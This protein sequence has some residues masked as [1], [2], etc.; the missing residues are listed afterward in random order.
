MPPVAPPGTKWSYS[1]YGYNLLGRVVKLA[2]GQDLSSA[3][4]QRIAGL[5][6]LHRTLLPTS[7]NG[8][9]VPFTHGYGTGDVGPTQTRLA[10]DDATALPAS[11]LWAHGGMVSTLSDMRVWTRALATGALL[12]PAVWR[13]ANKDLIPFVFSGS[14]NGPGRWRYGLGF[15]ESGG[16]LGGEAVLRATS[17]PPCT[18]LPARRRLRWCHQAGQRHHAPADDP[19]P[20]HGGLWHQHRLRAHARPSSPAQQLHRGGGRGCGVRGRTTGAGLYPLIP[21]AVTTLTRPRIRLWQFC[22]FQS[23]TRSSQ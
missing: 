4:Q 12:K 14:Y 23:T 5:L 10:S 3:I 21:L 6:G 1:N 2:T 18:R 22:A 13:E 7:G 19:G 11:C 9:S 17:Q 16:F 15:V 20:R 8:L